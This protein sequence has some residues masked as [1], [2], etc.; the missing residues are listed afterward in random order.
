VIAVAVMMLA[1][2]PPQESVVKFS[3]GL[4]FFIT[5]D[6]AVLTT[7]DTAAK[8]VRP[9]ATLFDGSTAQVLRVEHDDAKAGIA[10]VLLDGEDHPA[11]AL[12][13]SLPD[14]GERVSVVSQDDAVEGD[15]AAVR[16]D[17]V[18]LDAGELVGAPVVDAEGKVIGLLRAPGEA[19]G[20]PFI[21]EALTPPSP[22]DGRLR[23]L[24]ISVAFFLGLMGW[25]RYR[26]KGR[27][28]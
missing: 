25:W 18:T 11:L 17:A 12:T 15:V 2:T 4:G 10:V 9:E 5:S 14:A 8:I 26:F 27:R 21:L 19:L 13:R 7:H 3:G 16:G 24:G 20:A 6:G 1:A 23:N 22:S 28:Y